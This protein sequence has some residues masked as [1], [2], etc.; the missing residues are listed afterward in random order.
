MSVLSHL[1][2]GENP[3]AEVVYDLEEVGEIEKGKPEPVLAGRQGILDPS[4][5]P[6]EIDR[7][8]QQVDADEK[9]QIG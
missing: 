8:H 2:V 4:F 7:F 1:A 6:E 5:D 3:E 9:D